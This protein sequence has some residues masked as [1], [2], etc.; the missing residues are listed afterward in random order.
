MDVE[1]EL[2]TKHLLERWILIETEHLLNAIY[3]SLSCV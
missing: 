1:L 3:P 2:K